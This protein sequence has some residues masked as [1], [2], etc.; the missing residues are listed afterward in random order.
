[1]NDRTLD[2]DIKELS[3]AEDFLEYFGIE[4]DPRVVQVN[5]LHVLQRLH[6]YLA[7]EEDAVANAED[8]GREIYGRLLK[9]A[10]RDF[11]ESN[12]LTEKVFRVFRI[13]ESRTAFVPVASLFE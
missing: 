9:R 7:Q 10:Y 5:R 13:H 4:Y 6:D 12:A 8:G 3:S 11:V 2:E 1:M